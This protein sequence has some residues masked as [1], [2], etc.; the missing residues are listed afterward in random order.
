MR[1]HNGRVAA[2]KLLG[3]PEVPTIRLDHMSEAQL[4]AYVI[5][6][7]KLA[8]NAGWDQD[9]LRIEFEYLAELEIDFD[10][11]IT[12]FETA[13]IDVL[14]EGADAQGWEAIDEIPEPNR[15]GPAVTRVGDVWTLG[16]HRLLCGDARDY[17]CFERLLGSEQADV[18][19]IDPPYNVPINGHVC[20]SG[21]VKHREF[22]MATGEMSSTDFASFLELCLLNLA[23][24]SK[25]GSI[26][27][28]FID[29]RHMTELMQAGE[30]AYSELKNLCVWNK[31]NGGMGSLYR[32]KHELVF[33]FKSGSAPHTNNV[34]LGRFGRY[35]TNVWDYPGANSLSKGR[36]EDL[37]M[38]PTVKPVALVADAICDC[39]DRGGIVLDSFGG[40]GTTLI[41][42]ERTGRRAR[43]I[44]LDPAYVD[45]TIKRYQ[46]LAGQAVIHSET[47]LSF[48]EE[49]KRR[50]IGAADEEQGG[51]TD[52]HVG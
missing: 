13:E 25:D 37:A 33:V 7:N 45:L 16:P 32:S 44:E 22:A 24:F 31:D 29:W 2:A 28:V 15:T 4:R 27:F 11:T 21:Q 12:G 36:R 34:E 41:A 10:L 23:Q 48:E 3:L 30:V 47:G 46:D 19:F 43:V 26:H 14:L 52:S 8:E 38:H 40:S 6:D 18:I 50:D 17:Q 20:G 35:R 49:R 1:T 42:A 51:G 9:L 39:S 5:A